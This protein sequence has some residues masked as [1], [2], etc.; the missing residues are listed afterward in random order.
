MPPSPLNLD[1][2]VEHVNP[3]LMQMQFYILKNLKFGLQFA[4]IIW[5]L[6]SNTGQEDPILH[7]LH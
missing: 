1:P 5:Q 7:M 6:G 2:G 4:D 3:I